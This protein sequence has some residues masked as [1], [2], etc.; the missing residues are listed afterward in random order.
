MN[1]YHG[2]CHCGAVRFAVELEDQVLARECNCSI[3]Q[4]LGFQHLIVPASA[5]ALLSGEEFLTAYS[6]RTGVAKHT[7][8]KRC[9]V[10]SFYTPR[11]NPDGYSVNLRCLEQR[12]P[13]VDLEPFDGQNWE[14][15]ASE[16]SHLS[17]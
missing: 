12:P 1:S 5:F 3:C 11:S 16:L 15:H 17:Q 14:Q 7:F 13:R 2:G 6:F 9:G 8:C 4:M 10:K